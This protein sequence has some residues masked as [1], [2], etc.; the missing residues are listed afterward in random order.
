MLIMDNQRSNLNIK[1]I[2]VIGYSCSFPEG[3]IFEIINFAEQFMKTKLTFLSDESGN[4]FKHFMA[5]DKKSILNQSL[6]VWA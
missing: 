6:N 2:D 1:V 4:T 3:V 5:Q